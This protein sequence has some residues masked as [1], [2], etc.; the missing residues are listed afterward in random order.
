[1]SNM[2]PHSQGPAESR[3]QRQP[4]RNMAD[5]ARLFLEGARP[6]PTRTPPAWRTLPE[7]RKSETSRTKPATPSARSTATT[8]LGL[9]HGGSESETWKL[10][11]KAAQGMAEEQSTTVA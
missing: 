11:V 9:A 4:A 2:E 6:T 5:V 10:L 8:A 7:D 1:M 3:G